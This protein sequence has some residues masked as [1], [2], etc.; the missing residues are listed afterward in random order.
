[1]QMNILGYRRLTDLEIERGLA[2]LKKTT[3]S[4]RAVLSGFCAMPVGLFSKQCMAGNR[5]LAYVNFASSILEFAQS[6]YEVY[7][8]V[9]THPEVINPT[10]EVQN[11]SLLGDLRNERGLVIHQ[12][13]TV[14]FVPPRSSAVVEVVVDSGSQPGSRRLIVKSRIDQASGDFAVEA[15]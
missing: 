7:A 2:R 8:K 9:Q 12:G 13:Y 3:F 4:R 6:V 15:N 14:V 10:D 11:Q 1:M 5:I